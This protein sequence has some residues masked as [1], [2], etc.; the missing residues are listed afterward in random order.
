MEMSL[1]KL[2]MNGQK[3]PTNKMVHN[4]ATV[5][6]QPGSV[7]L[8]RAQSVDKADDGALHSG[9]PACFGFQSPL[10]MGSTRRGDG[11]WKPIGQH[12]EEEPRLH[13]ILD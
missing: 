7:L 4:Q 10:L 2:Y 11:D 1:Q 13:L 8:T 6:L 5:V 3:G 12:G 9:R